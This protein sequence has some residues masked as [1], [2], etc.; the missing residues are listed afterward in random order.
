MRVR[1]ALPLLATLALAGCGGTPPPSEP[2]PIP[3]PPLP[4]ISGNLDVDGLTAGVT[5]VRDRWGIPHI[6]ALNQDDLFFAQGFVQAQDRLFQMDLWRRSVQGRL[7]EVLGT[8]FIERDA[9][10][11]RMR[12]RGSLDA[13]WAS[14]G[15]DAKAIATAFVRGI[16]AWVAT[17]RERPPE[18]FSLAGW[19][20]EF[21]APEDLLNRTEAFVASAGADDELF[22]ARLSSA[23]GV[24]TASRLMGADASETVTPPSGVDLTVINYFVADMLRRVGTQPFFSGISG[25]VPG[26]LQ[27]EATPAPSP[28]P[29]PRRTITGAAFA[30]GPA[31]SATGA[32]LAAGNWFAALDS[33]AL[34]Y[35]VHLQAPG[36]NV[37]GATAPWRPGV[38]IGHNDRI[39]W[40][41]APARL[42]TQDVFVE[43]LNPANP[44]QVAVPGGWRDMTVVMESVPVKGRTEP[45]DYEQQYT[46]HGVVVALDRE[47]HLAYAVK[48]SGAEPGA[49][50]ELGALALGRAQSWTEFR[51]ALAAWKMPVAEFVYADVDGHIASQTAGLVPVRPAGRGTLP[52]AGWTRDADWRGWLSLDRLPHVVD[53]SGG[54][55]IAAPGSEARR[56]RITESH[57]DEASPL[58]AVRATLR[59]IVSWNASRLIPLLAPLRAADESVETARQ[60]LVA[61]HRI[62]SSDSTDALLYVAWEHAL[63]RRLATLRVP[64]MLLDE[65]VA[66]ADGVL[67]PA[68]TNPSSLW[69]D[70]DPA[71]TR[72]TVLLDSLSAAVDDVRRWSSG[73]ATATW[74]TFQAAAFTHPLA[75]SSRARRRYNVGPFALPG[76][77]ATLFATIR[78][79]AE[80]TMGPALQVAFDVSGWDRSRA[81]L[82]PGQAAAPDSPHFADLALLWSKGDDAPLPFSP[83]AVQAA[84]ESTLVLT[85]RSTG[86]APQL[87]R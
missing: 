1:G 75:V 49:A 3:A 87:T 74:G 28:L 2:P 37:I 44:H 76:Y 15:R 85:P 57:A 67:V 45:Y 54:L 35:L 59:D 61:W 33:P 11:R 51:T 50:P 65:F 81:I 62:V 23:V 25:P 7:A 18:E 64:S 46:A 58:A 38:A 84:S 36:W 68:F 73:D 52:S 48:W 56:Q 31:R 40:S 17:A 79:T 21:W 83:E 77:D 66:R 20:P 43:R 34:R 80:Q 86:G 30:L 9:M 29:L 78:A 71:R 47:R 27:P 6:T 22:R 24:P 60:R 16:N 82:P 55:A 72:D 13:E 53:P 14:Y 41:F 42:D 39:A 69:F 10:T 70:G 5:I 12:Y 19:T 63:L 8:N 4:Q 26:T 32:P